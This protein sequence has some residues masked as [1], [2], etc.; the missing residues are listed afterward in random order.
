MLCQTPIAARS[1]AEYQ[2]LEEVVIADQKDDD[3]NNEP[4]A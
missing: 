4:T 1:T 2:P 3:E